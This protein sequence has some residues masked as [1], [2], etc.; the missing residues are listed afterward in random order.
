[1]I[2]MNNLHSLD[3]IERERVRLE[4]KARKQE[5]AL[6]TELKAVR[7]VWQGRWERV[8]WFGNIMSL[9]APKI[10]AGTIGLTLL[11]RLVSHFRKRSL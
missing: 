4:R 9:I 11:G 6:G 2:E 3:Q 7:K 8:Q 5:Q 1:M 10:G